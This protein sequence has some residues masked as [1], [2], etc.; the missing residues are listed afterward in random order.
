M[1][2]SVEANQTELASVL[3]SFNEVVGR[4]Q[5]THE[6]LRGEVSRLNGELSET[7]RRLRRSQELAALG[8]MAAGIA[9]EIRNPLGSIKLYASMLEE[10]LGSLPEQKQIATKIASAVSGLDSIVIDV[11]DFARE[12]SIEAEGHDARDLFE[13][14]IESCRASLED[15]GASVVIEAETEREVL[16]DCA[17]MHRA[18]VNV[19]RNASEAT[20]VATRDCRQMTL[21]THETQL[22]D[23]DGQTSPAVE[24]RIEDSGDGIPDDV[25]ERMFNPFFTTRQTGTGLGL[26]IVH[27]IVDAHNGSVRV[28]NRSEGGARVS[29]VLPA[30]S[31]THHSQLQSKD[32]AH[33]N[34]SGS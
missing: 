33:E 2:Q 12:S 14:A 8:E 22:R 24:L 21:S 28:S 6:V 11:L 17:L 32:A 3:E 13:R 10:D 4:L 23:D 29:L 1:V 15:S 5:E 30:P 27:R 20:R 25:L 16:C 34:G 19:V 31:D 18:L 26:A 9:H 7:K